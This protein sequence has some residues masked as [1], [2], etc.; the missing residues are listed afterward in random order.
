MHAIERIIILDREGIMQ[1]LR[2]LSCLFLLLL[3]LSGSTYAE[4][5][6]NIIYG[7]AG[8]RLFAESFG[9]F[10][11]PWAM[12]FLPSGDLLVTEKNGTL[13]LV[14][15]DDRSKVPVKGVPKVAYGGQGGL[16]D[17]ILHPHYRG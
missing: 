7:N 4:S 5:S 15:P 8:S 3:L 16:G 6:D 1:A 2:S 14:R 10:N 13:L 9:E 11:E 17:I 12:T